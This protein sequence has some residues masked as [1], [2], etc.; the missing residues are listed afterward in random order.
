MEIVSVRHL[1]FAYGQGPKVLD[2]LDF[3][4]S[5]GSRCVLVGKNGSGKTTLLSILAGRHM[6]GDA[7][8]RVLGRPAFSDTSLV[9]DVAFIGGQFPFDV[10][11]S[12]D[13]ILRAR[14]NADA[15]RLQR[16]VSLLAVERSWRMCR[17]S[18]GQRR[19]VQLLLS[20]LEPR[21]LYL[22]D[23]VTTDLDLIARMDL[24]AFLQK[25]DATILYATHI[26]E[27]LEDWATHVAFLD[28]GKI[29]TM[30][31]IEALDGARLSRVVERWLRG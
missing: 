28:R 8:V 30:T 9:E 17:V 23:E 4:L 11:L 19:R 25:E 29:A 31:G 10:D 18:D 24:L 12:V 6:V 5:R 13:E 3:T 27:G 2:Q 16:L 26:L 7:A 14:A 15:A 22:L 20:L 21:Q 1:D